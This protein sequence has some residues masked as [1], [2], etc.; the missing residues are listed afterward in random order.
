MCGRFAN[1]EDPVVQAAY[2]I[3]K[4][5][6]KGWKPTWNAAPTQQQPVVVADASE[7]RLELMTWGWKRQVG[8][9]KGCW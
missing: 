3:A 8:G 2:F 7:R 9:A 4:L 5:V 6:A 1:S